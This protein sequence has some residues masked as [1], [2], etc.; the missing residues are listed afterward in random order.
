MMTVLNNHLKMCVV[1]TLKYDQLQQQR[2]YKDRLRRSC[3][4]II[5]YITIVEYF[6]P[7]CIPLPISLKHF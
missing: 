2:F 7:I 1:T 5:N 4:M 6:N 3:S